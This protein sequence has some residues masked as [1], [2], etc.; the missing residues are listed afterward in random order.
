MERHKLSHVE[1]KPFLC[2]DC[3]R[4]VKNDKQLKKHMRVVHKLGPDGAKLEYVE[5]VNFIIFNSSLFK[6]LFC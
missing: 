4:A 2:P 5:Q 1:E 3:G 6:N